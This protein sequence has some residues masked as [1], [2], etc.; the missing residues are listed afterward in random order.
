MNAGAET[1]AEGPRPRPGRLRGRGGSEGI[2]ATEAFS[3][4]GAV[5]A[6]WMG[7]GALRV[8]SRQDWAP[9]AARD[10][11]RIANMERLLLV[12]EGGLEADC[13]ALGRHRAGPG[14]ALWIGAGH[15][16]ESRLRNASATQPLR[17]VELWLQPDRVNAAPAVAVV[18]PGAGEPAAAG[19]GW[20]ALASG[21]G[22]AGEALPE[23][24]AAGAGESAPAPLRQRAAV[25][26]ATLRPGERLAIPDRP[27]R[28]W[29]E[30]LSGQAAAGGERLLD[31][32]GLGWTAGGPGAPA[33]VE[34]LPG[35][36]SRLLLVLLPG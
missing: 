14:A 8:L 29:L 5:D 34:A 18:E 1:A 11:G 17:L 28:C 6:A 25:L 10:E 4:G 2:A 12:L 19:S 3:R 20:R 36:P 26:L 15:G 30:L 21:D 16:L 23:G 33:A 35:G 27:G 22:P 9:G 24:V 13:G 31:G 7:W 32:D